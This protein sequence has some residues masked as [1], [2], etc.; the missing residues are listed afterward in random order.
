MRYRVR[1]LKLCSTISAFSPLQSSIFLS[2]HCCL[3]LCLVYKPMHRIL[4]F[5]S[6]SSCYYND[7]IKVVYCCVSATRISHFSL[8]WTRST[9]CTFRSLYALQ[10]TEMKYYWTNPYL[11]SFS[12]YVIIWVQQKAPLMN[13]QTNY[14][15]KMS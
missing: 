4:S 6:S 11:F 15:S 5:L 2:E 1:D 8:R 3:G 9:P 10:S 7:N 12:N 13:F 14:L